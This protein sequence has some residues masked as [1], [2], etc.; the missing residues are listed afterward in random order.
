MIHNKR[1]LGGLCTADGRV[2]RAG[3]L[4]RSGNLGEA[5]EEDLEGI[6]AVIDLRTTGEREQVPDRVYGR[7]YLA[8]PIF[9]DHITGISHE[10]GRKDTLIPDMRE[11][12]AEMIREHGDA[13]ERALVAIMAHD[14]ST[15]AILCD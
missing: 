8:I 15:G 10:K 14:F 13:F 9:D 7:E 3:L 1:D 5:A 12:Y 6:S 4:I 11:L 2:I